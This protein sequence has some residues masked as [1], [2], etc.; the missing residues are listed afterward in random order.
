MCKLPYLCLEQKRKTNKIKKL[1]LSDSKRLQLTT[2]FR[3]GENQCFRMGCG[4]ILLKADGL[5]AAQVGEQTE[6][7]PKPL[8]VGS[9]VSKAKESTGYIHV[10]SKNAKP[11]WTAWTRKQVNRHSNA[12]YPH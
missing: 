12:F 11:S 5:S 7:T 1:T 3:T 4:A 2:G 10:W 6:M 8:A 9:N